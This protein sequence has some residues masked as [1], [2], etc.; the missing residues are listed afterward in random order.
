MD[1]TRNSVLGRIGLAVALVFAAA[2]MASAQGNG[3]LTTAGASCTPSTNCVILNPSGASSVGL[4]ISGSFS[5][6]VQFEATTDG[7]WDVNGSAVWSSLSDD[8]NGSSS[9][10]STG[11][12][13]FSNPGLAAI[14]LR[15]SSLASGTVVVTAASGYTGLK[16]TATLSGDVGGNDAASATGSAVPA[17]ADFIGVSN[18]GT[19]VGLPGDGT[20]GAWVNCKAGCSGGTSDSD[21]ASIATGQSTGLSLSLGQ[22]YDGSVWRR[23]TIGT[24]GS[25]SSQFL[26]V[27]G[28]PSGTPIPVSVSNG[29]ATDTDDRD[30]ATGQSSLALTASV[31]YGYDGT[32]NKAIRS[33]ASTPGSGESGVVT[34]PLMATDGTNTA[35]AGD[36]MARSLYA[37]SNTW[38]DGALKSGGTASA[39]TGTT[40]TQVIAAVTSNYLYVT[41]CSVNNAH[42]SVD[43]LVDLQDGSGGTVIWTFAA[44]HGYGGEAH[45][46][47]PPLKVPTQG[48]AL[49][50]VDETTSAS[51]K[52]YCNGFSSTTSY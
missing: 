20:S 13:F 22:V 39:M 15:A 50:T 37:R 32:S 33:K 17:K 4:T 46:F 16:S 51:V 6:T 34:R 7:T 43:T 5:G 42:A 45:V 44:A 35:P 27:Q 2:G 14:R 19:L 8:V 40:S 21:D 29:S 31:L 18:S 24:A 10:T 38:A 12:F 1:S 47:N 52:V 3:A 28:S 49:Y 26:S 36:A 48:N 9:T 30:I 23:F 25:G 11:R 41:S